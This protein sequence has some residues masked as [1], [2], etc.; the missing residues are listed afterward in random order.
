MCYITWVKV[1]LYYSHDGVAGSQIFHSDT[2]EIL[3][4]VRLAEQLIK[5]HRSKKKKKKKKKDIHGQ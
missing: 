5:L 2:L 1:S 3:P 4:Y